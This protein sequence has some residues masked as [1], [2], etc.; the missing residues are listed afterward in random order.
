MQVAIGPLDSPLELGPDKTYSITELAETFAVTP[1]AIRFYEDRGLLNPERLGLQ[2]IYTR[3]DRARLRLILRGKRLGFS[4][5]DI[6]EMLDLYDTGDN[7]EQVKLTLKRSRERLA[8]L[9]QQRR[10]IDEAMAELKES[11]AV[12]VDFLETNQ[13]ETKLTLSEFLR[14]TGRYCDTPGGDVAVPK[15]RT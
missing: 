11:C 15:A 5:A 3:R 12:M 1:R 2:R 4:L 8:A 7:R 6:R 9:E 10:D 13:Q 14:R